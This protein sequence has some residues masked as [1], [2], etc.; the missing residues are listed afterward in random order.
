M[1]DIR[2][3]VPADMQTFWDMTISAYWGW[4]CWDARRASSTPPRAPAAS[5][6]GSP[7]RSAA[8]SRLRPLGKPGRVL[9]V[10]R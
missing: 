2:D 8:P 4:S 3:A 9:A 10:S 5:A 6:T 1:A 7:Q